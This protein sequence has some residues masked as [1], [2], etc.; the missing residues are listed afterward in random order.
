MNRRIDALSSRPPVQD[1]VIAVLT[2][3]STDEDGYTSTSHTPV[4]AFSTHEGTSVTAYC[5]DELPDPTNAYGRGA[6]IHYTP[7]D[8]PCSP[9]TS[10]HNTVP[11]HRSRALDIAFGVVALLLGVAAVV[12][13]AVLL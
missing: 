6:T 3:T 2:D 10:R 4:I 13:G 5:A 11:A 9:P 1:R 8:P 12:V 7:N